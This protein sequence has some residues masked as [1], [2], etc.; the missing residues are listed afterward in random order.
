MSELVFIDDEPQL[1]RAVGSLLRR[2]GHQVHTFVDPEEAVRF[3]EEHP[4][5]AVVCD[6]RMPG[7][8]G[9]DV[10]ARLPPALPFV[11]LSGD[12]DALHAARACGRVGAILEKPVKVAELMRALDEQL[13]RRGAAPP[14]RV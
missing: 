3:L 11:L 8:T 7:L 6:Y 12:L 9:L 5:D 10:L 1:C 4:V 2:R 13:G 14:P